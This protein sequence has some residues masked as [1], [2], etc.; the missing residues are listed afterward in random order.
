MSKPLTI[1]YDQIKEI[2]RKARE[3]ERIKELLDKYSVVDL[4][5]LEIILCDASETKMSAEDVERLRK[6]FGK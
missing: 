4:K 1:T 3:Y 6:M 5:Q 2:E